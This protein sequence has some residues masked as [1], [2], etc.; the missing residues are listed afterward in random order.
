MKMEAEQDGAKQC[1][2]P[3]GKS[4]CRVSGKGGIL[5]L[6]L[7]WR[8]RTRH[9]MIGIPTSRCSRR[10]YWTNERRMDGDDL[11]DG[12]QVVRIRCGR[13]ARK[14]PGRVPQSLVA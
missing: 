14:Y 13:D 8:E 12:P 11:T 10:T 2:E 5:P 7:W 6:F 4:F 1:P 3:S 9:D